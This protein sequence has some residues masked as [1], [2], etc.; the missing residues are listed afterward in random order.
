MKDEIVSFET[1]KLAKA[2]GFN[3]ETIYSYKQPVVTKRGTSEKENRDYRIEKTE[4]EYSSFTEIAYPN[5]D[6]YAPTQSLLQKWLRDNHKLHAYITPQGDKIHWSLSNV[7]YTDR[8]TE[9][10]RLVYS[11]KRKFDGVKFDSYEEALEYAI[12]EMLEL[13]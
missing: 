5:E 12:K 9:E 13:I 6:F 7:G 3:I 2:K 11:I 8:K 10:D 1:A 4:Y